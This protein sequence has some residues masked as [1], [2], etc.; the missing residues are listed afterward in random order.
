MKREKLRVA[1]Q[2]GIEALENKLREEV[3]QSAGVYDLLENRIADKLG[4]LARDQDEKLEKQNGQQMR[5]IDGVT[6]EL[7][8]EIHALSSQQEA[9]YSDVVSKIGDVQ[10][11]A[12][13]REDMVRLGRDQDDKM[14]KA[15]SQV[16]ACES[17]LKKLR[18]EMNQMMNASDV[19]HKEVRVLFPRMEALEAQ[20]DSSVSDVMKVVGGK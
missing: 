5:F 10:G 7:R 2:S 3:S 19:K 12:V 6:A 11:S 1:N 18:E 16:S 14:N 4:A 15:R 20:L 17:L 13:S 9:T 8:D